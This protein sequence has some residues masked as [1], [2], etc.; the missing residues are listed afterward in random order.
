MV[1]PVGVNVVVVFV[2][3]IGVVNKASLALCH[4][5]TEPT[6]P[7]KVNAATVPPE[8]IVW[9]LATDPPVEPGVTVINTDDEFA[10]AHVPLVTT[11]L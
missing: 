2:M 10:G 8:Q 11:A 3:S 5:V 1:T 9:L 7:V 4:F 6:L